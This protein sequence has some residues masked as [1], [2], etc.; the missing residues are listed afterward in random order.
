MTELSQTILEQYQIRKSRKQ[1]EA[2]ITF[3]KDRFPEL[4][5]E[6][7]KGS[8]TRNLILGD[9][10]RAKVLVSAHYDTCARMP[11]P[12]F[13]TPLN[14]VL[15]IAY[16]FVIL[17]PMFILVFLMN[18]LM[19]ALGCTFWAQ[20]GLS[21]ATGYVLLSLMI[22][23][24]A[25][26]HTVNDN[27]SGIISLCELYQ[28][29][30]EE[31]KQ[32]VCI[33]FFD[34]EEKGLLGSGAYRRKHKKEIKNQVLINLDCVSDGDHI[35]LSVSKKVRNVYMEKLK[36]GFSGTETKK[37]LLKKAENVYYPSDQA[38][39]PLSIAIAA[40]KHRKG[41]GYYMDRIHTKRD[42]V[43]D[44]ENIMFLC[45]SIVKLIKNI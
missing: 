40:L 39:F 16:G 32:R 21:V 31:D 2:F 22:F 14:P 34:N 20:Y 29:L 11:I 19:R 6:T 13:I 8:G 18:L 45:H 28:S 44:E 30:T 24:P 42:T 41:I 10:V 33:L 9:L 23:G 26:P 5:I 25:N 17:I 7:Y 35:L 27:T 15:S 12:N 38:G 37:I 4:V 3:L 1:K 43:M 36:A